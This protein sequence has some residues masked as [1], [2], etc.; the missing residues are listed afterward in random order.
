[1][2]QFLKKKSFLAI[3][4]DYS[5][6]SYL[7]HDAAVLPALPHALVD[8][9][10]MSSVQDYT[11]GHKSLKYQMNVFSRKGGTYEI[12]QNVLDEKYIDSVKKCFTLTVEKSVLYLPYQD[13]YLDTALRASRTGLENAYYFAVKLNGQFIGYQAMFK[14]G[15]CLKILNGAFDRELE[16]THHAYEVLFV[17][18]T[19]FAI[20]N[21]I[22]SIDFGVV[23]NAT[24]QRMANKAVDMSYFLFSKYSVVKWLF[25][26][27]MK[28]SKF[29][30]KEQ[31][32]F[33]QDA[34]L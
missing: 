19:E 17:K 26:K 24:K 1:M 33:R 18:M 5:D 7:F 25:N 28:V 13:I 34:K 14:T 23:I 12:I 22:K 8:T 4:Y 15:T 16:T 10:Q 31:M 29:Q 3:I 6:K 21:G 9:S 27:F 32:I 2:V 30:G 20:E 11:K